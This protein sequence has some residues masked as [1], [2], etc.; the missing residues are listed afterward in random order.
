MKKVSQLDVR[1]RWPR[2]REFLKLVLNQY[3]YAKVGVL[4][5]TGVVDFPVPPNSN[6]RRTSARTI[7][8][9]FSSA[10]TTYSPIVTM[11]QFFGVKFDAKSRV[12][13]FGCGVGRQLMPMTRHLPDAQYYAVD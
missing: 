1:D 11:A 3:Q 8:E 4:R 6:M 7:K 9:Y 10:L 2:L 12:L 5:V 13:D